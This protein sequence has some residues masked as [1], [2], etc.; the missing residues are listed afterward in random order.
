[1]RGRSSSRRNSTA[2]ERRRESLP[3]YRT[4]STS[5]SCRRP[6]G[7]AANWPPTNLA[8]SRGRGG[9]S[10]PRRRLCTGLSPTVARPPAPTATQRATEP[11]DTTSSPKPKRSTW[12]TEWP[13]GVSSRSPSAAGSRCSGPTCR[14]SSATRGNAAS[15]STSPRAASPLAAFPTNFSKPPTAFRSAFVTTNYWVQHHRSSSH[16]SPP[17]HTQLAVITTLSHMADSNA[18][19]PPPQ[20]PAPATA[21]HATQS[22]PL[23]GSSPPRPTG[24]RRPSIASP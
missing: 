13:T 6:R 21:T 11:L 5:G 8:V 20:P 10:S 12:W 23:A 4:S 18:T 14:G 16:A 7:L 9:R 1:M 17:P 24:A 22:P 19:H 2:P 15:R 3:P